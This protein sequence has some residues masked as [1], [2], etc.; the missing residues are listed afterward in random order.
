MED[1]DADRQPA[2]LERARVRH[3]RPL[4]GP[5]AALA[6]LAAALLGLGAGGCGKASN[7]TGSSA[8]TSSAVTK[9]G[10]ARTASHPA[11][12]K[13]EFRIDDDSDSD[14]YPH[15]VDNE[16]EALGRPADAADARSVAVLIERYYAAAAREDGAAACRL[17]YST[18]ADSIPEDYGQSPGLRGDTCAVVLSK[19]FKQLHGRLRAGSSVRVGSVRVDLNRARAV[20]GF[21]GMKLNRYTLAHRERGVWKMDTLL[22]LDHPIYVE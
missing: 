7:G 21:D 2:A 14:K 4:H 9:I 10:A 11:L 8:P 13:I 16:S 3:R 20:L 22:D 12:P 6:L 19:L 1:R 5:A 17:I 15:E 18:F